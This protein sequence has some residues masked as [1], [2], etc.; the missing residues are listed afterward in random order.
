MHSSF[1]EAGPQAQEVSPSFTNKAG[2]L[3]Y[4][5]VGASQETKAPLVLESLYLSGKRHSR[6]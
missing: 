3:L 5:G 1:H 2:R 4:L 6:P